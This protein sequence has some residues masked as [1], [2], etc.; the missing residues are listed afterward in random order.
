MLWKQESKTKMK[1]KLYNVQIRQTQTPSVSLI[2][3]K[4][5]L[6]FSIYQKLDIHR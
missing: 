4:Q 6:N 1:G 3:L 2:D 5:Q